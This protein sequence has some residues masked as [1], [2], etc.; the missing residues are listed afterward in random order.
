MSLGYDAMP[1]IY[2]IGYGGR[3]WEDFIRVLKRY[4]IGIII[5]VRRFPTSKYEDYKKEIMEK[6]LAEEGI[7]YVH[8]ESLGGYRGEYVK[9]MMTNE[10]KEGYYLLKKISL[11]KTAAIMCKEK[12]VILCH[13]KYISSKLLSDGWDVKHITADDTLEEK[14]SN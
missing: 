5:D 7:E 12:N 13:R 11:E 6:R 14:I 4:G 2:T 8:I 3:I 1:T 10:W 9:H